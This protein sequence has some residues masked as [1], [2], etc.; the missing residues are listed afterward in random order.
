MVTTYIVTNFRYDTAFWTALTDAILTQQPLLLTCEEMTFSPSAP[1][2]I[3]ATMQRFSNV[4]N[5]F[6]ST[7]IDN[8]GHVCRLEENDN[9]IYLD[10]F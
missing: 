1:V 3:N 2:A 5:K 7:G 4:S 8:R 6:E 9:T 10:V